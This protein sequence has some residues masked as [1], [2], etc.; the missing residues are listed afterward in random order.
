M[1][2]CDSGVP[3]ELSDNREQ[4]FYTI[5][6]YLNTHLDETLTLSI[7]CGKFGVSQTSLSSMFREYEKT[8]FNNYLTKIRIEKAKQ[9]L[10]QEPK[11]FIREVA[12]RCGYRDQFYFSRIFRTITGICPKDYPQRSG[13]G[14][15]I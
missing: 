8:S 6:S 1:K 11:I 15:G 3:E 4:L 9:I 5:V 7:V 12:E 2:Q 10:E 14:G 13:A